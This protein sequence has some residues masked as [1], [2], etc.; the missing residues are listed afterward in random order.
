MSSSPAPV[1]EQST[2]APPLPDRS[3][4][5]GRLGA[6]PDRALV[7][8]CVAVILFSMLMILTYGYGRDQGIYAMVARTILDGGMPYRDAWDFKP[9]GI[10]LIYA[11][12]RGLFGAS[13][14]G[15]RI[16]E[17]LGLAVTVVGM[18][19]LTGRWW[20]QW[21]IGLLAGAIAALIHAQLDFWHTAQPETFGGMLTIGALVLGTRLRGASIGNTDKDAVLAPI[22][23]TRE[24]AITIL[25]G[26]VFGLA[27]LLKPPLA[28]GGA[29]V[30]VGLAWGAWQ[31]ERRI[32]AA[33]RPIALVAVGGVAPI[34][35]CL[36]WFAAK[37]ALGD[38]YRVLL[39]FTPHYT[40]LGWEGSSLP[41]MLY[42]GFTEWLVAYSSVVTVGLLVL[43]AFR[44]IPSER[45]GVALLVG[46]IAIHVIGVT[47]QGKF[48]PYHYGA[49]WPVTALLVALGF[50]RVWEAAKRRG[51]PMVLAW[52]AAMALLP[53]GRTAAKDVPGSYSD[54]CF[55]RLALLFDPGAT[56]PERW[57]KLAS[58]ADVNSVANQAVADFVL[59]R[60]PTNRPILVWGFE[61]VIYDL[62]DRRPAT[63]YL[64][65]VPQRV[66]WGRSEARDTLMRDLTA[67][68]PA[69]V[70]VERYDV[71]PMV[72]GELLD[73][74][75]SL[76]GFPALRDYLDTRYELAT[77]I[78]DFDIYVE[79]P[80][81]PPMPPMEELG[82]A[83]QMG[84][85]GFQAPAAPA[86]P[87]APLK[88]EE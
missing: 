1:T 66:S 40:K 22:S 55:E 19:H 83:L 23:A 62:T 79:R 24:A 54:R 2:L 72:T 85:P 78:E 29:I 36:A 13:Q 3:I 43:L 60:T 35:L 9:P 67:D 45:P 41:G 74:A 58:V 11:L 42:F 25:V 68:P 30:A 10:F 59:A 69:M 61:P 39:V 6:A 84:A 8:G 44:P 38:L 14:S 65:N 21:R 48:F 27:G 53:C 63:R 49:T 37:G 75:D 32:G 87:S 70:I 88:G 77:T 28:G 47:M 81:M 64:Y 56:H 34:A 26:A 17:A 4:P 18:A 7:A 51:L 50:W 20:G 33:L 12:A 31:R 15:I 57:L 71:F 76:P 5:L 80:P 82:P 86:L 16:F 52:F 46:I 73:S